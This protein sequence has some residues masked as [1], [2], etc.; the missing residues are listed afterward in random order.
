MLLH[1]TVPGCRDG[2]SVEPDSV[3][4][5][6]LLQHWQPTLPVSMLPQRSSA[7]PACCETSASRV[8][9]QHSYQLRCYCDPPSFVKDHRDHFSMSR[10]PPPGAY[11]CYGNLAAECVCHITACVRILHE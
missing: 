7:A 11:V 5:H 9:L 3:G 4:H 6:V 2:A 8:H 10:R 1:S